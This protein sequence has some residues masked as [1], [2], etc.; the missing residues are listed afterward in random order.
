MKTASN[1]VNI[2]INFNHIIDLVRQLPY[3][4]KVKLEEVIRRE[5]SSDR[6]VD[7]AYTHLASENVLAKEWLSPEEDEAWRN[8]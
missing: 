3:N 8:L 5:I 7:K 2:S 1:S 4:E 6:S